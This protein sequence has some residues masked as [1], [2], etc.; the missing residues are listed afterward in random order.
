MAIDLSTITGLTVQ[1][2]ALQQ[3]VGV[4]ADPSAKAYLQAQLAMLNAQLAAEAQ[5]M[6]T[7]ADSSNTLMNTL[8]LFATLQS[9]VGTLAP[10]ILALFHK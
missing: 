3:Q 1:I 10:T 6:Q 9:S 4:T 7:Q 8:G 2:N 5:H